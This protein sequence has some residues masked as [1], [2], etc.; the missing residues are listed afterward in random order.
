[1]FED[2]EIGDDNLSLREYINSFKFAFEGEKKFI[3][4]N[5][6]TTLTSVSDRK[7]VYDLQEQFVST[8]LSRAEE[9]IKKSKGVLSDSSEELV[10][11]LASLG[12]IHKDRVQGFIK[13][14]D[15]ASKFDINNIKDFA[16]EG[17]FI[18]KLNSSLEQIKKKLS[19]IK[20]KDYEFDIPLR[21]GQYVA[22]PMMERFIAQ[23]PEIAEKLK[24]TSDNETKENGKSKVG[25]KTSVKKAPFKKK[26]VQKPKVKKDAN[27]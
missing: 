3:Q 14:K 10:K 19:K 22:L 25:A 1:M 9:V 6:W 23:F 16:S 21:K 8:I 12:D 4:E 17:E 18:A 26:V 7:I 13:D 11:T 2:E 20:I 24:L 5:D 27:S 15:W